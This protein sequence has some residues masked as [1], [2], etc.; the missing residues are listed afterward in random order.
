M[1]CSL[2]SPKSLPTTHLLKHVH[3]GSNQDQLLGINALFMPMQSPLTKN[4]FYTMKLSL[5]WATN[6]IIPYL[7]QKCLLFERR[8]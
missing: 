4:N 6:L 2:C 3:Q 8:K 7:F 1:D 5:V